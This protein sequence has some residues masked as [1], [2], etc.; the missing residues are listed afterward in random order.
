MKKVKFFQIELP[1]DG[2]LAEEI[3]SFLESNNADIVDVKTNTMLT[4][5]EKHMLIACLIYKERE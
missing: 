2:E 4:I 1:E 5:M 3:N